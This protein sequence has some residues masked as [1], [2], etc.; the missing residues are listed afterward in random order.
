MDIVIVANFCGDFSRND[1][2][3]FRYLAKLLSREHD[4]ELI[5]SDFFHSAKKHRGE[6]A[7]P[8]FDITLLHEPGYPRNVCLKRFYSHWILGRN[9]KKYL[10]SRKKP[11]IVYCAVPSLDAA[12]AAADYARKNDVFFVL[13]IQ[14]LW[15]E[16]FKVVFRVSG[17]SDLIF[18]PMT[19]VANRIYKQADAVVAVSH[20]Y[21]RRATA[22]NAKCG[23]GC[24]VFLG[25]NLSDFDRFAAEYRVTEKKE[26][27]LWLAYCGTLGSN[28]DLTCVFRALEILNE[29]GIRPPRFVVMGDGPQKKEFEA[30]ART[31]KLDVHFTGRIPYEEMCGLL[32]SCD[33]TVNPIM[34]GSACS[35]TNKHADYA[36]CGKP[37]L[38]TME[39]EEYR[40]LV[41]EYQMGFNCKNADAED[42]A[43]KLEL[44]LR[45]P[46][47]RRKMGENARRCAEE[48]FDRAKTYHQ[49]RAC[50]VK[51]GEETYAD[52]NR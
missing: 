12:Q 22:V 13:D 19:A 11:D 49:I 3:R 38:N 20:T 43:E 51:A 45:N 33:I 21:C 7:D 32:C 14:D 25:T 29:R 6:V 42:L 9:I 23:D 52:S 35:I 48:R 16:A 40:T 39:S 8:Q 46:D 44:L 36:A 30:C 31:K 27:E 34:R 50:I 10:E 15:P 47:L 41:E 1:N 17:I 5:T 18:A 4:V 24:A 28:Y 37:V 26:G 2:N